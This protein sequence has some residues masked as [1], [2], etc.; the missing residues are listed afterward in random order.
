MSLSLSACSGMHAMGLLLHRFPLPCPVLQVRAFTQSAATIE[1]RPGGKF[2]WFN[3]SVVGEFVEME[4]D[5]RLVMNWRFSTWKE[6]CFSKVGGVSVVGSCYDG[7]VSGVKR[8]TRPRCELTFCALG[9]LPSPSSPRKW[10]P[11]S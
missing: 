3:G 7:S 11:P 5:K 10:A 1:A 9:R 4:A 2:S 6:G 8:D